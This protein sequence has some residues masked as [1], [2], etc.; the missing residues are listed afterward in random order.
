MSY[1]QIA[2]KTGHGIATV[3]SHIQN[4]KRNLRIALASHKTAARNE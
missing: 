2:E 3:K 4:G 1:R